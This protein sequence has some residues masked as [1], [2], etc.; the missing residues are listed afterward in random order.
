[1]EPRCITVITNLNTTNVGN[2]ALSSVL[3]GMVRD[4]YSDCDVRFLGRSTGLERYSMDQLRRPD[5]KAIT[6]FDQWAD[7][8]VDKYRAS[9][10]GPVSFN[11]K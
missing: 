3:M 9:P 2:Q 10:K 8:E 6:I 1:M 7:L 11:G 5:A 4:V